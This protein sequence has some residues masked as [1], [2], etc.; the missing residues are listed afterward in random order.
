MGREYGFFRRVRG[1]GNCFYRSFIYFYL[2][3]LILRGPAALARFIDQ[4]FWLYR[5]YRLGKTESSFLSKEDQGK[6]HAASKTLSEVLTAVRMRGRLRALKML[7]AAFLDDSDFDY[8]SPF[9]HQWE[10]DHDPNGAGQ[11]DG[12]SAEQR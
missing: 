10:V 9:H 2:E 6:L 8:A 3:L 4:Y 11:R 12:I 5:K 1:D 7:L